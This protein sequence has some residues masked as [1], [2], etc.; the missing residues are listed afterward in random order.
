VNRILFI[1]ICCQLPYDGNTLETQPQGGSESTVTRV[2]QAL[3]QK[4]HR[5]RITQHNREEEAVVN[6]VEYGGLRQRNDLAPTHVVTVREAVVLDSTAKLWPTAKRYV[7]YHDFPNTGERFVNEAQLLERHQATALS[8]SDWHEQEWLGSLRRSGFEGRVRTRRIYN[9][10]PDDL[11]PDDTPVVPDKFLFFSSP[12]KGLE[13]TLQVFDRF[14]EHPQ[15]K[16]VRLH[17]ANPGY[18]ESPALGNGR[19][20]NLGSLP[21]KQMIQELRSAYL[22]FHYNRVWPETFGLVHAEADAVG[23]P[24]I[25]GTTGANPEICRH[26][27]EVVDLDDLD[28]VLERIVRWRTEGRP[29]VQ[30]SPEF[31]LS[32][33]ADEWEAFLSE[34]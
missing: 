15:L 17:V 3:A 24:W 5:V 28:A 26:P 6:G 14:A 11:H 20:V 29:K 9:P 25:S 30:G 18:R 12:H 33:I 7:W 13:E 34:A 19:V 8:V 27:D 32:R 21:W 10:I 1:D 22:V 31:R 2:A 16:G 4:G 23:T